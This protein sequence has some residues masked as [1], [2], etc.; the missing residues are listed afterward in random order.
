MESKQTAE[1]VVL[2][3]TFVFA[4][5]ALFFRL[6]SRRLTKAY[7]W[8]DD[9]FAIGCY[10]IAIIWIIICPIWLT[11]GLGLHIQDVTW[12]SQDEALYWSKLLLYIAELCYAF[13]LFFGKMSILSFYWR[14]FSVTSIKRP[15]QILMVCSV[16]WI[17]IRTFLGIFHCIPVQA[18]W[19]SSVENSYCA[20][21]DKKFFFGSILVH[22][23][24]DIV[25]LALPIIQVRKLH[26]PKLQRAGIIAMFMFGIFICVAAVAIII[27]SVNFDATGIDFTWNITDI[28]IW[29][30]VEVNLVTVSACLP[31][32]RPAFTYFFG[33]FLPR[34]TMQSGS[35]SYGL[36]NMHHGRNQNLKSIKLSTMHKHS[37][38]GED[39]ST[40]QL[41]DSVHGDGHSD[42][43]SHALDSQKGTRT[44]I[45]GFNKEGR[46]SSEDESPE[47]LTSN[48]I[49]VRSETMVRVTNA[50][51]SLHRIGSPDHSMGSVLDERSLP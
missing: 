16:I 2:I 15:I 42:F 41:A 3:L 10:F 43:E 33:R 19:D 34:S 40:Y 23:C 35:N 38:Q 51:E 46:G 11:K 27:T 39:S 7:F 6:Y 50:R 32:V 8:W 14:L 22:V 21:N 17:T 13:A 49:T 24:L 29:A 18:F 20:I 45:T 30:T 9:A 12:L 48:G 36:S 1:W 25:I 5:I 44:V 31:T 37:N 4:S 26:L 28:V 47:G